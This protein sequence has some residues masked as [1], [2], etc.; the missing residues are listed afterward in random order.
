MRD[1]DQTGRE[2]LA[3]FLEQLEPTLREHAKRR[4]LIANDPPLQVWLCRRGAE[5]SAAE[6][7]FQGQVACAVATASM[8]EILVLSYNR[9]GEIGGIEHQT[10]RPA[11]ILQLNY[12]AIQT[13]AERQKLKL[14]KPKRALRKRETK[15]RPRKRK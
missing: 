1:Y 13:E 8:T 11:S 6:I 9:P 2:N 14:I 10:V 12:A 3:T 4:F 15:R 5:P 7:K